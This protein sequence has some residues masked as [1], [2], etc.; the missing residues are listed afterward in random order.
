LPGT[1]AAGR[2]LGQ[3]FHAERTFRRRNQAA[4]IA[5]LEL[6]RHPEARVAQHKPGRSCV[7]KSARDFRH[8]PGIF[9]PH[10]VNFHAGHRAIH[11]GRGVEQPVHNVPRRQKPRLRL[12]DEMPLPLALEQLERLPPP[13]RLHGGL[14]ARR[15]LLHGGRTSG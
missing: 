9:P 10:A 5:L 11:H 1:A 2:P 6:G 7:A 4:K 3:W 12:R 13:E 14:F 15:R 8:H